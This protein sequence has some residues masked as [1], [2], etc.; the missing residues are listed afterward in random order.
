M[1]EQGTRNGRKNGRVPDAADEEALRAPAHSE[2]A[3]RAVLGA[4]LVSGDAF[5]DLVGGGEGRPPLLEEH[6]YSPVHREF[7]R[8]VVAI[9]NAG[10]TPDRVTVV[11][12]LRRAGRLDAVGGKG[13]V[14]GLLEDLP[15]PANARRHAGI[16]RRDAKARRFREIAL[17]MTDAAARGDRSPEEMLAEAYALLDDLYPPGEEGGG[18]RPTEDAVGAVLDAIQSAYENGGRMMGVP[19]GLRDLDELLCGLKP[20]TLN[21][22]AA[23]PGDGKTALSLNV[24]WNAASPA[25][26]PDA[27]A[28]L[29]FSLEMSEQELIKRLV[30]M[31][32]KIPSERLDKG[33]ITDEE[34]PRLLKAVSEISRRQIWVDDSDALTVAEMRA[35]A[36]RTAE[37][38]RR[39]GKR[40][41]L[42]VVDYAQLVKGER[43]YE[44]L[45]QQLTDVCHDL[46]A[47]AGQ[48]GLPVLALSQLSRAVMNRQ[49]KRPDLHDLRDSG[50][51][52]Q[53]AY[54]VTFIYHEKDEAS[55]H[56][57]TAELLVKK[58]RNGKKGMARVA[59]MPE[60]QRFGDIARKGQVGQ[61]PQP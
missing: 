2:D 31:L 17:R 14:L 3:E 39:Q 11:D 19:T 33:E 59:W 49:D 26:D 30:S 56:R 52:E 24:M 50:S 15:G 41:V 16:V 38:L 58:H 34:W 1:T 40:L 10:G 13:F 43:R 4:M 57:G 32:T 35:R 7:Y 8:A 61:V 23:R 47:M 12:Q 29:M 6:F 18:P 42:V 9:K 45:N 48:L 5:D 60:R 22:L 37:R 54:S 28:V 55:E 25:P 27:D 44:N 46:K 51:L 21:F 53:T 20:R 36:R